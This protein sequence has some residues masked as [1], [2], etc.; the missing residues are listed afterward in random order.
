MLNQRLQGIMGTSYSSM[1]VDNY[2]N[3]NRDLL[4]AEAEEEGEEGLDAVIEKERIEEKVEQEKDELV[5]EVK[6]AEEVKT[7]KTMQHF[8]LFG[9]AAVGIY[10]LV[11]K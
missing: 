6:L 3:E 11:R 5:E 2:I 10:F 4:A 1:T 9:L 7:R 8:V